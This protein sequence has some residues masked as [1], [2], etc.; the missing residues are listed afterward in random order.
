[1]NCSERSCHVDDFLNMEGV[2]WELWKRRR[3]IRGAGGRSGLFGDNRRARRIPRLP[4]SRLHSCSLVQPGTFTNTFG[5][6]RQQ[7]Q[8]A[9]WSLVDVG[10]SVRG[11]DTVPSTFFIGCLFYHVT[12][13]GPLVISPAWVFPGVSQQTPL[14]G[15]VVGEPSRIKKDANRAVSKCHGP[16]RR[17][18]QHVWA[19]VHGSLFAK[20]VT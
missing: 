4:G 18:R 19:A 6:F 10:S 12:R 2:A 9:T 3:A 20:P 7:L 16:L 1:M 11:F 17:G 5:A 15:S 14:C 13:R 8:N